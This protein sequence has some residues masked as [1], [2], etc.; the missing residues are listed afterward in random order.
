MFCGVKLCGRF[1]LPGTFHCGLH[2]WVAGMHAPR[3][4]PPLVLP[5]RP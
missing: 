3:P 4:R 1:R 5:P 2:G